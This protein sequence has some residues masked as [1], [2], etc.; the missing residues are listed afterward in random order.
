MAV[1]RLWLF[2]RVLWS[3]F[4][5]CNDLRRWNIFTLRTD[6]RKLDEQSWTLLAEIGNLTATN[7]MAALA[8]GPE[9]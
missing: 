6:Q 3:R 5:F 4:C 2:V 8:N 1:G 7:Q 9:A